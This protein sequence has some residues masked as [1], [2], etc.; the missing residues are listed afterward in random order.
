[1]DLKYFGIILLILGVI[2]LLLKYYSQQIR[3]L[4]WTNNN[5]ENRNTSQINTETVHIIV[6]PKQ[7]DKKSDLPP[8]YESIFTS[9]K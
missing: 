9:E 3:E 7:I 4:C 1:M 2:L 8:S 6:I 5:E